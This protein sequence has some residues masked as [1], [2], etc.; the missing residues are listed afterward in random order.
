M[1]K[2]ICRITDDPYSDYSDYIEGKGAYSP[3]AYDDRS[4]DAYEKA[5]HI[6]WD[7]NNEPAERLFESIKNHLL[8]GSNNEN[9]QTK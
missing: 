7:P 5:L 2:D 1:A 6:T 4:D 8:G 3:V 9:N